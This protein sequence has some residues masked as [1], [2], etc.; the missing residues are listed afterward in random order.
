[1]KLRLRYP[2]GITLTVTAMT[3]VAFATFVGCG[4]G[5]S[6]L[7]GGGNFLETGRTLS[8]FTAV[9]IDPRS[10]DSAGPQFVVAD[11]VNG[12]GLTDLVSVWNQS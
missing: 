4:G 7:P 8:F 6:H 10:E 1:M 5:F 9:Q 11:D 2:E 12:D 3:T